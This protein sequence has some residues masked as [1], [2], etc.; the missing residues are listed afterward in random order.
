MPAPGHLLP[1]RQVQS[2]SKRV[3]YRRFERAHSRPTSSSDEADVRDSA[4]EREGS[5]GPFEDLVLVAG[6]VGNGKGTATKA[7]NLAVCALPP[8]G[9]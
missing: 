4:T 1:K 6:I 2:H 3:R 5:C 9:R 8:R 7:S